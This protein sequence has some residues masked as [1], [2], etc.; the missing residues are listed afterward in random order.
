MVELNLLGLFYCTNAAQPHLLAAA[1]EPRRVADV[2]N[3]SSVAGR[4][5]RLNNGVYNA[6]KFGVGAFSESL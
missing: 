2:V 1:D 5:A 6:T 4:M 3:M